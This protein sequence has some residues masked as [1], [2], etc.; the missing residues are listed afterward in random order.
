MPTRHETQA[1][2]FNALG[3]FGA[4]AI[5]WLLF[6]TIVLSKLLH[7][8]GIEMVVTDAAFWNWLLGSK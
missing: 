7:D 6:L 2:A 5:V 1:E 4:V 8:I 3:C